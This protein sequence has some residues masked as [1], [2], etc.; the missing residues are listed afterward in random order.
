MWHSDCFCD[1]DELMNRRLVFLLTAFA[2]LAWASFAAADELVLPAGLLT[3]GEEAFAGDVSLDT[4]ILPEGLQTIE[5]GAFSGSSVRRI[6]LPASISDIAPDAFDPDSQVTGYGPD[7]TYAS[8]FFDEHGLS[9]EHTPPRHIALLIGNADYQGEGYNLL[10]P[11]Y[12]TAALEQALLGLN[13][14]WEVTRK[15]NLTSSEIL[16]WIDTAFADAT[17]DDVCLFYYSGHSAEGGYLSDVNWNAVS[18]QTLADRLDQASQGRVIVLLDCCFSGSVITSRSSGAGSAQAAFNAAVISAFSGYQLPAEGESS[19]I[20]GITPRSGELIQPKFIVLTSCTENQES[21]EFPGSNSAGSFY[22]GL[23]TYELVRA[24]GCSYPNGTYGGNFRGDDDG[25]LK[26]TLSEAVTY[27]TDRITSRKDNQQSD[28][29]TNRDTYYNN[30][31]TDWN[32]N[33]KYRNIYY[34]KYDDYFNA[35]YAYLYHLFDQITS[36]YGY[37]NY[38]MFERQ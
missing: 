16:T 13:P 2:L 19:Q 32:A 9:F 35:R 23:M 38:V 33:H 28:L 11:P 15:N 18:P 25:D 1:R 3:I 34:S 7:H 24:L 5:A 30:W 12:D 27:I 29:V 36:S 31:Q 17:S 21:Y 6:Y 26:L 37:G 10:G 4:V 14:S 8:N 20:N 22:C